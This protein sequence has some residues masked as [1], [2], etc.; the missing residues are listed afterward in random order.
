MELSK[1]MELQVRSPAIFHWDFHHESNRPANLGARSIWG[2]AHGMV[3]GLICA[4]FFQRN[5]DFF[6]GEVL[7][8]DGSHGSW[9]FLLVHPGDFNGIFVGASRPR[10]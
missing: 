3:R 9:V 2:I 4:D 8:G 6:C 7:G 5:P 10:K 1:D